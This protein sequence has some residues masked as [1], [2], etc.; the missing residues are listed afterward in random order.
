M[1]I[2]DIRGHES[3]EAWLE[4]Q[5]IEWARVIATRIAL[6][7]VPIAWSIAVL[8]DDVLEKKFREN[9]IL[10]TFR[11]NFLSY[12][13]CKYN[14]NN[15]TIVRGK[16]AL[17]SAA[18]LGD[19][20][21]ET[22]GFSK[23][24]LS[25]AKVSFSSVRSLA[26][27]SSNEVVKS[28]ANAS[29]KAT[30]DVVLAT[31]IWMSIRADLYFLQQ[32]PSNNAL[33]N[34]DSI[35]MGRR[36]I[37]TRELMK[38]PLWMGYYNQNNII[39]FR[40]EGALNEKFNEFTT[41]RLFYET[42]FGLITEWYKSIQEGKPSPFGKEA[43]IAIA[44]MS[45]A[46]WGDED[47]DRDCIAVMDLVAESVGGARGMRRGDDLD[48]EEDYEDEKFKASSN[49][50]TKNFFSKE[51]VQKSLGEN[52]TTLIL[53]CH[54]ILLQIQEYKEKIRGNNCLDI[55]F[56][57]GLMSFL[58]GIETDIAEIIKFIPNKNEHPSDEDA[59]VVT[60]KLERF[61]NK[62]KDNL[63]KYFEP[64]HLADIT[65][66]ISIIMGCGGVGALF[67]G[68]VGFGIGAFVGKLIT[69]EAK[70]G[71]SSEKVKEIFEENESGSL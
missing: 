12:V 22:V 49:K 50:N 41:S 36:Q 33:A 15:V 59:Q 68:P 18:R 6:R 57:G 52:R 42:S 3:L 35:N 16:D 9:L 70:P 30:N 37:Q 54:S 17:I 40:P 48:L 26:V 43:E 64:E 5:P 46:D 39:P 44:K 65:P 25:S 32:E 7:V 2:E 24:A 28:A 53:T 20:F 11:A 51:T 63:P 47:D 60:S 67:G 58:L 71:H 56:K 69:N 10:L 21:A 61:T 8:P 45:P 62:F 1:E 27:G 13:Y 31:A 29:H 55:E 38:Q 66:P 4:G 14:T 19:M 23:P 34:P